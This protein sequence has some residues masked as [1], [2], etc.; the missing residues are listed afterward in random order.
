MS[1]LGR[2]C[3]DSDIACFFTQG[4]CAHYT[5]AGGGGDR[6]ELNQ[7]TQQHNRTTL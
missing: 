7:P 2:F 3:C 6:D 4:V 5:E 1:G